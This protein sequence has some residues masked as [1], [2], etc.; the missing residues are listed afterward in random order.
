MVVAV[1]IAIKI[2]TK[3]KPNLPFNGDRPTITKVEA[4]VK[5]APS[6]SGRSCFGVNFQGRCGFVCKVTWLITY[7]RAVLLIIVLARKLTIR[8]TKKSTKPAAINACSS[9]KS[10]S[11]NLFTI[12]DATFPPALNKTSILMS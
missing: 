8:V 9:T 1:I 6:K 10:A 4:T 7:S 3:A 5:I 11:P 12:I 2:K